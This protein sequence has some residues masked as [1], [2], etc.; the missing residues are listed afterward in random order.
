[1]QKIKED[2]WCTIHAKRV[3]F[4]RFIDFAPRII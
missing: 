1:M 3:Q 2:R 4:A